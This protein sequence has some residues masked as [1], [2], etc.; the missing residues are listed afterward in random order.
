MLSGTH[1]DL[2]KNTCVRN[3]QALASRGRPR[4][5]SEHLIKCVL[6]VFTVLFKNLYLFVYFNKKEK[7]FSLS[8]RK[9]SKPVWFYCEIPA[10]SSICVDTG[11]FTVRRGVGSVEHRVRFRSADPQQALCRPAD[12]SEP[13][14]L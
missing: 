1:L 4:L 7:Q 3:M 6:F 9:R 14:E 8:D 12:R 10:G 11:D 2:P 5:S 13:A